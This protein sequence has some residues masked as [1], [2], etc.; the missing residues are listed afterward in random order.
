[1]VSG[2]NSLVLNSVIYT[3]AGIVN[4][5][6]SI[7]DLAL[8]PA[9]G[10]VPGVKVISTTQ[11][12]GEVIEEATVAVYY[13]SALDPGKSAPV[14]VRT[15]ELT[16]GINITLTTTQVFRIRGAM[17]DTTSGKPATSGTIGLVSRNGPLLSQSISVSLPANRTDF[18]IA[19]VVP[20]SY[21]LTGIGGTGVGS[22][23]R[24]TTM[25]E[26]S[27]ANIDNVI[28]PI[29]PL[30]SLTGRI[31]IEGSLPNATPGRPPTATVIFNPQTPGFPSV[32]APMEPDG[33]FTAFALMPGDYRISFRGTDLVPKSILYNGR[34]VQTEGLHIG[35][36]APGTLEIILTAKAGRLEGNISE[37]RQQ[38]AANVTVVLVPVDALRRQTNLYQT[39]QSNG[40][41][42][43]TIGN[44]APGAYKLFAFDDVPDRAWF[45]VEFMRN[46]ESQG[47]EITIREGAMETLDIPVIPR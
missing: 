27:A 21:L 9:A 33:K 12:N 14:D 5:S 42:H 26:V 4:L 45:D 15:G 44:I 1:M 46:F 19:G 11:A 41:G 29:S 10:V 34:D 3:A 40:E 22:A 43:Y 37:D 39:V 36:A 17:I 18:E 23:G 2:S 28:I 25:V 13:P 38:R 8:L 32:T 20:G 24:G 30:I 6:G 31:V 47:R 35:D 7:R 16:S